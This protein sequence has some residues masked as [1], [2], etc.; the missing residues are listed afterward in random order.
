MVRKW[1]EFCLA[2]VHWVLDI[3]LW[4]VIYSTGRVTRVMWSEFHQLLGENKGAEALSHTSILYIINDRASQLKYPGHWGREMYVQKEHKGYSGKEFKKRLY[5]AKDP[6][7]RWTGRM[8]DRN[9]WF[10]SKIGMTKQ[11]TV[12]IVLIVLCIL[13]RKINENYQVYPIKDIL[14]YCKIIDNLVKIKCCINNLKI[15]FWWLR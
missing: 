1:K 3:C 4:Q 9:F 11:F 12:F 14:W 7:T 10:V 6:V 2:R 15:H 8:E 13:T 5:V